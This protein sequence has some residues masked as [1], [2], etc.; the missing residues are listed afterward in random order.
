MRHTV[1]HRT[2]C[3][4]SYFL[5]WINAICYK[6]QPLQKRTPFMQVIPRYKTHHRFNLCL[7][8]AISMMYHICHHWIKAIFCIQHKLQKRIFFMHGLVSYKTHI[9]CMKNMSAFNLTP[10]CY[11]SIFLK[12]VGDHNH[13]KTVI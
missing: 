6:F 10:F 12:F 5:M 3:K 7:S 9:I 2:L 8:F 4:V 13:E 11:L 1:S